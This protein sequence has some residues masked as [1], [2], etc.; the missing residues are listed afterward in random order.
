MFE[1]QGLR[2]FMDGMRP[3]QAFE[4]NTLVSP[5]NVFIGDAAAEA[6]ANQESA[7]ETETASRGL[8][9]AQLR[10]AG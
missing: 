6:V 8:L 3:G 1:K 4:I 5:L 2:L 10:L 7:L 9:A